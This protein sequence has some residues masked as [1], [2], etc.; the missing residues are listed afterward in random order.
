MFKETGE[1]ILSTRIVGIGYAR[2]CKILQS[3]SPGPYFK[4]RETELL[5]IAFINLNSSEK[6]YGASSLGDYLIFETYLVHLGKKKY[7]TG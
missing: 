4:L 6:F 2:A 3:T 1:L 7:S 5:L